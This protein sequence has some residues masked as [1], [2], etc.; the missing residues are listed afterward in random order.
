MLGV[1]L[2]TGSLWEKKYEMVNDMNKII[3]VTMEIMLF[4]LVVANL[5]G[6]TKC[7]KKIKYWLG[8]RVV[9]LQV[10]N[11]QGTCTPIFLKAN[12]HVVTISDNPDMEY[13]EMQENSAINYEPVLIYKNTVDT[14]YLVWW[15]R[16]SG[17]PQI[18]TDANIHFIYEQ[19]I[20]PELVKK[21]L[22]LGFTKFPEYAYN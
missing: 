5:I 9:E 16:G 22:S 14:L 19:S 20:N 15:Y 17:S 4:S 11:S 2:H 10:K 12:G 18:K 21:Y 7:K 1:G 13:I 6:C 8:D 3:L